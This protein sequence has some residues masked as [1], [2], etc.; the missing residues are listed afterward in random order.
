MLSEQD[1]RAVEAMVNCNISLEELCKLFPR[2]SK[3]DIKK[4]MD[5]VINEQDLQNYD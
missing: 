2:F 5:K 1:I 4:I 3:E